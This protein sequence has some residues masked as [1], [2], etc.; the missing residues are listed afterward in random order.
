MHEIK[1]SALRPALVLCGLLA[2]VA[3]P[4]PAAAPAVAAAPSVQPGLS[5]W[6]LT[7]LYATPEAWEAAYAATLADVEALPAVRG[8]LAAS[9]AS[10]REGMLAMSDANRSANRLLTYASLLADQDLRVSVNTERQ[11]RAQ[12]LFTR[13]GERTAWVAPELIAAGAGRIRGFIA[14]DEVLRTRFDYYLGNVLRS[15]PHTLGQEAEQVLAAAGD[16]QAQPPAL[17]RQLANAE[18]PAPTVTLSDG[19][20]VKL[21]SA[22]YSK[23]R[24]SS[25]RADRK[26]VFDA[27]WGAWGRLTGTGQVLRRLHE[28]LGLRRTPLPAVQLQLQRLR[29][30][31]DLR[32]RV[33]PRGAH[34]AGRQG[35]AL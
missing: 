1:L 24:Y 11:Q 3:V 8:K 2:L 31:L 10:L 20:S 27:Y 32:A 19:T 22:A 23:Y 26:L 15:A 5:T 14:A 9:A 33:R 25:N 21:D 30:T 7:D 6:D 28:R 17:Q 34:A 4:A 13:L 16:L 35:A 12:A 29:V 18:F